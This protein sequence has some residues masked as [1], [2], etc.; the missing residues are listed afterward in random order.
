LRLLPAGLRER[1]AWRTKPVR[2]E[3]AVPRRPWR[4][5]RAGGHLRSGF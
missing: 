1:P 5:P 2:I 4:G 3:V